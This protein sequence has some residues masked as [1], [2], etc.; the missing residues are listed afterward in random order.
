MIELEHYR[1]LARR[2]LQLATGESKGVTELSAVYK[3]VTE[4]R[5][6][7]PVYSSC[8]DLA[9]WLWYRLG[10]RL[11]WVNRQE[12][13]GFKYGR[14]IADIWKGPDDSQ[15]NGEK[16]CAGDVWVIWQKADGADAH[17]IVCDSM[18]GNV[19]HSYEYGQAAVSKE[20]W[21]PGS[22]EGRQKETALSG[23][24]PWVWPSGKRLQRVVRLAD[25][26]AE[27]EA[28]GCLVEPE[29][30]TVWLSRVT[31]QAVA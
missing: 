26:L 12:H 27:A 22:I 6:P 5:D 14:N 7:G 25:V 24:A 30:P 17:V 19:L 31:D 21:R 2:Y 15:E 13:R 11:P 16:P 10:V 28:A 4:R 1:S 3:A 9:H 20:R 23:G 8:G 29:D 18:V